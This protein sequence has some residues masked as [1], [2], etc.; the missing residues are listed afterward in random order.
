[1]G[2]QPDQLG[3]AKG[4]YFGQYLGAQLQP[5]PDIAADAEVNRR[6]DD[7]QSFC[8]ETIDPV[9]IENIQEI[10]K[11]LRAAGISILNTDHRVRETLAITDHSYVIKSGKVLCSGDPSEV[12]RHPEARKH[13]F[14]K[15]IVPGRPPTRAPQAPLLVRTA[16]ERGALAPRGARLR[17]PAP[18]GPGGDMGGRGGG[19]G[20]NSRVHPTRRGR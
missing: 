3:F 18:P 12:P 2:A 14:G 16:A 17:Q 13:Y 10:V 9:T 11:G 8:Q 20:G 4:L 1:V 6:V 15:G 19:A 7:L 5:Y